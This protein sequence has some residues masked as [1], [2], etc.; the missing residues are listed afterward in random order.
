MFSAETEWYSLLGIL[1]RSDDI[2]L[3]KGMIA[4]VAYLPELAMETVLKQDDAG[5]TDLGCA[6]EKWHHDEAGFSLTLMPFFCVHT[7][8]TNYA[9]PENDDNLYAALFIGSKGLALYDFFVNIWSRRPHLTI[10]SVLNVRLRN[11]WPLTL[12]HSAC[13]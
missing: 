10:L 1:S 3:W 9:E 5:S 12:R 2:Q 8:W 13:T 6:T 4:T 11:A 7:T